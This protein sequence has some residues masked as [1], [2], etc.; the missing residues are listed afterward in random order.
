[1]T[2]TLETSQPLIYGPLKSAR[3]GRIVS[4]DVTA[5]QANMVVERGSSLPRASLVVTTGAR[6]IIDLSKNGDKLDCLVVLGSDLDPTDHPDLR[7]IAENLRALRDKWFSRAK[8][9]IVTRVRDLGAYDKRATLGLF[10]RVYVEYEW[11]TSKTFTAVT[12]EKGPILA[13]L[14]KQL[15]SLEH[16]VVQAHLYR[17]ALD[18]SNEGE[19]GQW[20]K[21]LQEIKPIEVQILAGT[22][23]DDKAIKTVT[24]SRHKQIIELVAEVG[25]SVSEHND[26]T[27]RD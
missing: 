22:G 4:V 21:K 27:F 26:E 14:T 11:G 10:D 1:M 18:N 7:E 12:G 17:G 9:C 8:L 19:V 15:S 2:T 13:G 3:L 5:P 16:V 20:V 23:H 6:R 24:P 25:L